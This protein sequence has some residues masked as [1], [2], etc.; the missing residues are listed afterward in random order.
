MTIYVNPLINLNHS[1]V[2]CCSRSE[3]EHRNGSGNREIQACFVLYGSL[4]SHWHTPPR[5]QSHTGTQRSRSHLAWLALP[6]LISAGRGVA[7]HLLLQFCKPAQIVN[8]VKH[9]N[10]VL[11]IT[12]LIQI[13]FHSSLCQHL[14]IQTYELC[15]IEIIKIIEEIYVTAGSVNFNYKMVC[16]DRIMSERL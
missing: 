4:R 7:I 15:I 9:H 6:V 12:R 2:L 3:R 13:L 10:Q 5:V 1:M 16:C 8:C 14:Q 11:E